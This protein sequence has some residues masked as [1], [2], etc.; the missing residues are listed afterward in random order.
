MHASCYRKLVLTIIGG[1]YLQIPLHGYVLL[2]YTCIH[3]AFYSLGSLQ[4]QSH[5]KVC[6]LTLVRLIA[7]V[8]ETVGTATN[9]TQLASLTTGRVAH[10][11][12]RWSPNVHMHDCE[13]VA[14][15]LRGTA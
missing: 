3:T 13:G 5:T 14:R 12:W 9:Q 11:S 10:S 7:V 1:L 6:Q 2:A 8:G 15:L 4:L